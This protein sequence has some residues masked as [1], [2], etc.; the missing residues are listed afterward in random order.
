MFTYLITCKVTW[1]CRNHIKIQNS[2]QYLNE[3]AASSRTQALQRKWWM[4]NSWRWWRCINDLLMHG[5]PLSPNR[6]FLKWR[7]HCDCLCSWTCP[8]GSLLGGNCSWQP[9]SPWGLHDGFLSQSRCCF[10]TWRG[11][12][13]Y[14]TIWR[15]PYSFLYTTQCIRCAKI[16]EVICSLVKLFANYM[17]AQNNKRD[18]KINK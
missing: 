3:R 11:H 14:R 17:V 4:L 9:R 15:C 16:R 1:R 5:N 10:S 18:N 6:P 12:W 2:R 13:R 7:R 8:H